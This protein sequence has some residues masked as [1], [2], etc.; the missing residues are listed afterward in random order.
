[1]THDIDR[2]RLLADQLYY[3]MATAGLSVSKVTYT[4]ENGEEYYTITMRNWS[5]YRVDVTADSPIAAVYDVI[6]KM[7]FR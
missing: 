6:K 5:A 4:N 7:R 1:M 2:K 3:I